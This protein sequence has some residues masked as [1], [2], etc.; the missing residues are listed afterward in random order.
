MNAFDLPAIG[1]RLRGNRYPGRGIFIGMTADGARAAVAYFLMGRSENSRNRVFAEEGGDLV[2]RLHDRA[3]LSDPSLILYA[4]MRRHENHLIITNGDQTDT[5][6]DA[7]RG[8]GSFRG[9]L[10]TREFE[11]DAPNY[12]PRISGM[13]TFAGGEFSYQMSILKAADGAGTACLRQYFSYPA[14]RGVGHII[15]TYRA[16]GDPIPSFEGEPARAAVPDAIDA[17]ADALWTSLDA[18]NRV[19]LYVRY[20][21]VRTGA[22]ETRIINRHESGGAQ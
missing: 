16:D 7:V 14:M 5:I 13:L 8:G 3:K 20:V 15:H 21:D 1:D 17:C 4:P 9:A 6:F 10:D 19:A 2:I 22:H 18:R 11:P 12:T